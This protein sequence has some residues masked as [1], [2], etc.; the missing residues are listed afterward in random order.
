MTTHTPPRTANSVLADNGAG[1]IVLVDAGNYGADANYLNETW[2]FDGSD[3]TRVNSGLID[4]ASPL[5]G[6]KFACMAG[7]GPGTGVVLFGGESAS[8]TGGLLNDTWTSTAGATWVKA[9]PATS[10]FARSRAAMGTRGATE[11]VMFGGFGGNGMGVLL[12]TWVWND[13]TWTLKSPTH[14]PGARYDH[15]ICYGGSG[16]AYLGGAIMFGGKGTN[17]EYQDTWNWT[18]SDWTQLTPTT[19]PS[20]RSEH[21]MGNDRGS[22]YFIMFG[23]RDG[24]GVKNDTWKLDAAG[25]AWTKLA[26]ATVPP[27]RVGAK[28]DYSNGF[29][30]MFGGSNGVN[31]LNDT[32]KWDDSTQNWIQL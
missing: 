5:P 4:A 29:L 12:E 17:F 27:A 14:V 7:R 3:W 13:T 6:R 2:T 26:P 20:C 19:P 31:A 8:S 1:T 21:C 16:G 15:T 32:W 24:L 25:T 22:G 10:P 28:M 9:A 23:G 11:T 18:G 30:I